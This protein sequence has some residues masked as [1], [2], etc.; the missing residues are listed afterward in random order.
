MYRLQCLAAVTLVALSAAMAQA[1]T[2]PPP[3]S[4]PAPLP[5][6]AQGRPAAGRSRLRSNVNLR[7][8]P[9]TN[10]T[11]ITLI[12]AGAGVQFGDCNGGWCQVTYQGQDGYVIATSLG[13]GGGPPAPGPAGARYPPLGYASAYPPP[14]PVYVAPP[15]YYGPYYYYGYRPY[16]YGYGPYYGWHGYWR[17]HW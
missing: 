8:G 17:R 5:A 7:R 13:Q 3:P 10:Y 15:P 1:Q 9:G 12:P 2:A 6:L 14:A 4:E 11:T 16:Y